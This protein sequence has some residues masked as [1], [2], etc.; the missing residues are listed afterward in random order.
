MISAPLSMAWHIAAALLIIQSS[1]FA[2]SAA[3]ERIEKIGDLGHFEFRDAEPSA[4]G[5][6]V[7]VP[8]GAME[9]DLARLAKMLSDRTGA[10]F[11][12]A[13]GFESKRISVAEPVVQMFAGADRGARQSVFVEVKRALHELS[14]GD[15]HLYIE[16]R[17]GAPGNS[18]IQAVFSGFT[19]AEIK[20]IGRLYS[21]A[22]ES[23]RAKQ[24]AP[25]RL[26]VE[27]DDASANASW[28]L[29]HHG[30]L[31]LAE[32]G[33]SLR[34]P[35]RSLAPD[36]LAEQAQILA[37]WLRDISLLVGENPRGLPQMEVRLMGVGRFDV[38][39]RTAKQPGVVLGA[40]H[41]SYDAFT[42]EFVVDAAR[43]TGWAAVIARGFTPTE[44][45][46][47]RRINV[48]RPTER[49]VSIVHPE[50]ETERAQRVYEQYVLSVLRAAGAPLELYVE[51]HQN[52]G[53]NIEVATVGISKDEAARIKH[54]YRRAR[55]E[56]LM[57]HP[58]I[59]P[60]DLRIEPLDEIE[61]GAW[62]AKSSGILGRAARSLHFE[63]PNGVMSFSERR[64]RYTAVLGSLFTALPEFLVPGRD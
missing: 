57:A 56:M 58:H 50:L 61:V 7:G 8:Q 36:F 19:A 9:P 43:R 25:L 62:P 63:L 40:P 14:H 15:T 6:V 48:N 46:D 10:G 42:A 22:R 64:R 54:A 20:E 5:V 29:R 27:P 49:Y 28:G 16:L 35:G 32:Q 47:G 23:A 13:Y 12:G 11:F 59:R 31:L 2:C 60:V 45:G 34:L 30:V 44:T 37:A 1:L 18:E 39:P 41:G 26:A 24:F 3:P 21:V 38:I 4:T 17:R 53:A 52:N 51:V 55:H 33:L